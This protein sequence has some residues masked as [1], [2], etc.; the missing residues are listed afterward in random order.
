MQWKKLLEPEEVPLKKTHT[1]TYLLRLAPSKPQHW[2][3]SLKVISSI[4]GETEVCGI[5]A[6]RGHYPFS[7]PSPYRAGRLV[8]YLRLHQSS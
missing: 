5:K 2:G 8:P 1:Q 3:S 4:Q 7:K 6:S